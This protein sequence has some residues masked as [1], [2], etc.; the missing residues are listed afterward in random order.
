[1]MIRLP[2][3]VRITLLITAL[4]GVALSLAAVVSLASVESSLRT[5]TR[6]NAEAL[7]SDYL[8]QLVGGSLGPATPAAEDATRFIYI[9]DDGSDLSALEYQ[10]IL[11]NA[12]TS[13]ISTLPPPIL[14][15]TVPFPEELFGESPLIVDSGLVQITV[16]SVAADGDPVLFDR[17]EDVI[18]VGRPVLVGQ[19]PLTI[20]VSIP[21]QP[22]MDSI[23]TL[24][25][26]AYIA[27]PLLVLAI[28]SATWM[29]VGR[30]LRPVDAIT[31]QVDRIG[32][33][34]LD[35]RVPEP[36]VDDEIGHL[37]TTM[38]RMLTRLQYARDAQRQFISDASHE[39]RSPI[40]A[41]QATLEVARQ[42]P[43]NVDWA[44]TAEVLHEENARLSSLV[45]DLLLLARLEETTS[46]TSIQEVDLD[47]LCLT[48]AQRPHAHPVHVH[49]DSP[50]RI[51]GNPQ[52]LT[53]AIRNLVDNADRHATTRVDIT[54]SLHD[55]TAA[56]EV[57]DDGPGIPVEDLDRIFDRFSRL[58]RSRNRALG[59]GAGLGLA[60]VKQIIT[61]HHGT[62]TAHT[63]TQ[64]G[65]R[66]TVTMPRHASEA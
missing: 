38:N 58:D 12:V 65:A 23:D 60:I 13:E 20:A 61:T 3:R 47:E 2:L 66:F 37:A 15:D 42:N 24:T 17:G 26:S 7:L 19:T 33:N 55:E 27:V 16:L 53:R 4:F 48:E 31:V 56:I 52:T 11:F 18:V 36:V 10:Q 49:I 59:E 46:T 64:G 62:I 1:M 50:A 25:R 34:N 5:D 30:A 21:L 45:D 44:A 22:V 14:T 6:S 9:A 28:G 54:V 40:A 39:L 32:S 8:E 51:N 29:I 41:T 35:E 63:A 57:A 43:D